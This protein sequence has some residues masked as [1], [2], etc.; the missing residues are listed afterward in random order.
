MNVR[1]DG[2]WLRTRALRPAAPV[3]GLM[4]EG[5]RWRPR[6]GA[7]VAHLALWL[8]VVGGWPLARGLVALTS[9]RVSIA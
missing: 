2:P 6:V 9:I 5:A 4:R 7:M 3:G 1:E 8:L